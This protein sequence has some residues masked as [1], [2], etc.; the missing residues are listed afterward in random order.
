MLISYKWLSEY[1][2]EKLPDPKDLVDVLNEYAFE[3]EGLNPSPLN[4]SDKTKEKGDDFIIDADV[5]P[6]RAHDALGYLGIAREVATITG[7]KLKIFEPKKEVGTGDGIITGVVLN[8]F[9]DLQGA[10]KIKLNVSESIF[11]RRYIGR[12]ISNV[13]VGE[14]PAELKEKLESIGQRSINNIV[15][16]TN[17][18]MWE[19][20][21][22]MH[23]FDTDKLDGNISVRSAKSGEKITTL[24]NK[25]VEL[26]EDD[27]VIADGSDVLAIAGIKGG[28]KAEVNNETKNIILEAA[29]F[30]PSL[31][32]KTGNRVGIKTDSSKRFENEIS[33]YLVEVAIER[34][35]EL[36]LKYASNGDTKVFDS[37]EHYPRP[38]KKFRTGVSVSEVNKLLGTE[39]TEVEVGEILNK[40]NFEY[41]VVENPREKVLEDA[42]KYLGVLYKF[43]ASVMF[44]S[45]DAFDCSGFVCF[46]HAH[47]GKILPR[48]SVDQYVFGKE[49]SKGNAL[50]GD[51]VFGNSGEGEI[52]KKTLEFLPGT[53][54]PE[55]VD[56]VGI[57]LGENQVL[58]SSRY[59]EKGVEVTE[60][61]GN[62][63]FG[64]IIGYRSYFE[65]EKRFAVTVPFERL[66]VKTTT[67]LI[68]EI[69]RVYGYNK[70]PA[71]EISVPKF[72]DEINKTH[73]IIKSIKNILV[74]EGFSEVITY[75]FVEKGEVAPAKPIAADKAFLRENITEGIEKALN[76]NLKNADL[77]GLDQIKIFEI[78]KVFSDGGKEALNLSIGAMNK[79]GI[80]KPKSGDLIKEAVEKIESGLGLKLN[81][82]LNPQDEVIEVDL[83][84]IIKNSDSPESYVE[85]SETEISKYKTFSQYPFMLR[86]V[87]VWIPKEIDASEL[88]N[89]L[90][91]NS[92]ELLVN[93]KQFDVYE[94]DEKVS[95]AYRLVFQSDEKTLTDEEVNKIMDEINKELESRSWEVR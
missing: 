61:E 41:E 78:G 21:Q 92:G 49:I 20:N 30:N 16:I 17:F 88:E 70:I 31:V 57:Y 71:S 47:S 14:S 79:Q 22:P 94:K 46:I 27:N 28:K 10:G 37:V 11:C 91:E 87:A 18:V 38:V 26:T 24:D 95:Y 40:L 75:S 63:S 6:N 2:D 56:H 67:E 5:L 3:I 53:P 66:D 15:D 51:L 83:D 7:K 52:R 32:R 43:G 12:E 23:A 82:K 77:L 42:K 25:E 85:F 48:V 29:N 58:H 93:V 72:K 90:K 1:F 64:E 68:E 84:K 34:A 74:G 86:D 89:L 4:S 62:K 54:V 76:E 55:G 73:S 80:K 8:S 33:P 36:V 44:D 45:P 50:P 9:Q 60:L 59:N 19:L 35:T 81:A 39:I 65:D 69:G 13:S